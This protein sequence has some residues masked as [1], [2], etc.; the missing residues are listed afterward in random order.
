VGLAAARLRGTRLCKLPGAAKNRPLG[1]CIRVSRSPRARRGAFAANNDSRRS[2]FGV[3]FQRFL[4]QAPAIELTS[5]DIIRSSL[6]NF[7]NP[8]NE[9]GSD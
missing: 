2:A 7:V 5:S 4:G 6:S 9:V 8:L 1:Y 3:G